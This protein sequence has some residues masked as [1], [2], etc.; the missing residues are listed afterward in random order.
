M[1]FKSTK[2][3]L[4]AALLIAPLL[5]FAPITTAFADNNDSICNNNNISQEIKNAS[6]CNNTGD[7]LPSVIINILNGV[8]TV[9]GLIAVIYVIYGGVQYMTSTGDAGKVEKARKT[10]LYACLGLIA[11]ILAFA[12]VNFVIANIIGSN[13]SNKAVASLQVY[14]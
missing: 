5:C 6:G 8:I 1:K 7:Q 13:S 4:I 11:T 3:K 10:I 9:S 2:L 12:I 14:T